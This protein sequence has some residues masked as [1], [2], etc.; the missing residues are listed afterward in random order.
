MKK[1]Y[2]LR[3]QCFIPIITLLRN[4][5]MNAMEYKQ[6]LAVVRN[7]NIDISDFEEKAYEFQE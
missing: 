6:E 5:A 7:Q 1:M 2:K 3:P 4:A